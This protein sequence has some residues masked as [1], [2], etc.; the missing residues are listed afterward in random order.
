M[1]ISATRK[2]AQGTTYMV[3]IRG[4]KRRCRR[5]LKSRERRFGDI[6]CLVFTSPIP[7][8]I[9]SKWDEQTATLTLSGN[10]RYPCREVS[11]PHY[12]LIECVPDTN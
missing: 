11:V 9:S 6:P 10:G 12:D 5:V 7:K 1:E 2:L 3:M 4:Q 8:T